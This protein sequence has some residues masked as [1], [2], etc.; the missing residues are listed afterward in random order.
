M[1]L[2]VLSDYFGEAAIRRRRKL[3]VDESI[4]E[5]REHHLLVDEERREDLLKWM[6][7]F[8]L[9]ESVE[10]M[11]SSIPLVWRGMLLMLLLLLL[12]LLFLLLFVER[13]MLQCRKCVLGGIRCHRGDDE[14]A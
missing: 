10:R 8:G 7:I 6:D 14:G 11:I 5:E 1:V 9:R 12:F 3:S 13:I 2:L 4:A